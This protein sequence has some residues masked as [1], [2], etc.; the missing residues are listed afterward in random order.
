MRRALRALFSNKKYSYY[1][2]AVF[3]VNM[4]WR[5]IITYLPVAFL[6]FRL[7]LL[8]RTAAVQDDEDLL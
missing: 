6:W 2:V 8:K 7:D 1:I 4:G 3:L 5:A